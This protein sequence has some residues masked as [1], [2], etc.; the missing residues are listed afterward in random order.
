M[1]VGKDICSRTSPPRGVLH[2]CRHFILGHA[3]TN[4][5]ERTVEQACPE[6]GGSSQ[7]RDFVRIFHHPCALHQPSRLSQPEVG[8]QEARQLR[9]RGD[10]QVFALNPQPAW[11]L[12]NLVPVLCQPFGSSYQR[13]LPSN[14]YLRSVNLGP[15]LLAVA[16]ISK[17]DRAAFEDCENSG[18]SGKPAK[19]ANVGKMRDQ[20][21]IQMVAVE[22]VLQPL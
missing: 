14:H 21:R 19:V 2:L 1:M 10:G 4:H 5:L 12:A 17:E 3:R 15:G 11:F 22:Y 6:N 13:R 20:Q 7:K 8:P 16:P 9:T 18:C